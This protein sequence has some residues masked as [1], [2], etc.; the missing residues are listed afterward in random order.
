MV[1]QSEL[2]VKQ[3]AISH[4]KAR[5]S[6]SRASSTSPTRQGSDHTPGQKHPIDDVL[7][8]QLIRAARPALER[9]EPV[10]S[11]PIRNVDRTAGAMLSGEIAKRFGHPA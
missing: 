10:T 5:G 8:R 3:E 9:A 6:I 2:L 4:W 7:D 11:A 1:G